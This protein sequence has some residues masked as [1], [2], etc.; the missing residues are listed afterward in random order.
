MEPRD[1]LRD[2]GQHQNQVSS[3]PTLPTRCGHLPRFGNFADLAQCGW[4][5]LG[6]P[7]RGDEQGIE[8]DQH[9]SFDATDLAVPSELGSHRTQGE[10]EQGVAHEAL[11]PPAS[12]LYLSYNESRRIDEYRLRRSGYR[13]PAQGLRTKKPVVLRC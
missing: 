2:D 4:T 9:E 6:N 11:C 3:S 7:D 5:L 13:D 12:A 8:G 1:F 10:A